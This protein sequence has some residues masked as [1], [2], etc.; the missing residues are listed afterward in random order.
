MTAT[1]NTDSIS[2]IVQGRV[3][4]SITA[5]CIKKLRQCFPGAEIIISTWEGSDI[6][7]LNVDAAL[8]SSDPGAV[9]AD[10]KEK[11]MNNVNRQLISTWAG[12]NAATRPYLLKTRTDILFENTEFLNF[13]GKYD[14]IPS[15]FFEHRLLIC[16]YYTRNPRAMPL[17][18]HPSDWIVFGTTADVR[19]YYASVPLMGENEGTW[20]RTHKKDAAVFTNYVC[21]YTPEQ[22]IFLHFLQSVQQVYCD[23]YYHRTP[24]LVCQTEKAFAECFVVLDFQKE[25]AI[26]FPKYN[27]N[28]YFEKHTLLS[29]QD[30]TTLYTHYCKKRISPQWTLYRIRG[31]ICGVAAM[32]RKRCVLILNHLGWKA[33][34]KAILTRGHIRSLY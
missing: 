29:H 33:R 12:L 16:N 18:F 15:P 21:R 20:F 26:S 25:L 31:W 28:R 8:F 32:I 34:L 27:P 22:H 4:S 11:T 24:D 7:G 3:N 2:I 9:L 10:E 6:S 13:F 14:V 23:C 30:W 5:L 19:K 1:F 17:C